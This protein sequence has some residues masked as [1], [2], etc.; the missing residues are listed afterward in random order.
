MEGAFSHFLKGQSG[1]RLKQKIANGQWKPIND[2]NEIE[3]TEGY[4]VYSTINTNIQDITHHALLRQLEKYKA[5]HGCAVV[6]KTNSGEIKSIVNLSKTK[7][8]N[9]MKNSIMQ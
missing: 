2:N 9:I 1:Q 6:M 7:P 4:D 8:V 3:P 5:D